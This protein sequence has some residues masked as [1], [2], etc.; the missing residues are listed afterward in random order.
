MQT[1]SSTHREATQAEIRPDHDRVEHHGIR[2]V[3]A[4]DT[5]GNVF[6]FVNK[7]GITSVTLKRERNCDEL[8][9]KERGKTK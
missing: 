4:W 2:T 9:P 1:T 5:I 8:V 7:W 6:H 3:T